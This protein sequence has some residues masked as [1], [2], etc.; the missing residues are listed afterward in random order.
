[1]NNPRINIEDAVILKFWL[2]CYLIVFLLCFK[3]PVALSPCE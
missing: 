3:P 1:M 2:V